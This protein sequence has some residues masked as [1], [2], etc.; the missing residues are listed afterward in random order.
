MTDSVLIPV[1]GF[2]PTIAALNHVLTFERDHKITIL[3]VCPIV[4]RE[5]SVR[6][7]VIPEAINEQRKASSQTAEQVFAE[8]TSYADDHDV[9][10]RIVTKSGK[11]AS[12]ISTYAATHDISRIVIGGQS[13]SFLSRIL[14]GS[15]PEAVVRGSSAPVTVIEATDDKS[16]TRVGSGGQK[17]PLKIFHGIN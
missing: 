3:H 7:T 9:T 13:Q 16:T 10:L 4:E 17:Q 1:N 5:R 6:K 11:P 12:Q 14:R 2:Q 8:A 15:L